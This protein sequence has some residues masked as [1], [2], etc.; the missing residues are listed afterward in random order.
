MIM[1]KGVRT[2]SLVVASRIDILPLYSMGRGFR[3]D[4]RWEVLMG[5]HQVGSVGLVRDC[6]VGSMG[7]VEGLDRVVS[8]SSWV[9]EPGYGLEHVVASIEGVGG[10]GIVL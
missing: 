7:V 2:C 3:R 1:M 6:E 5:A 10:L 9:G 8:M 4:L